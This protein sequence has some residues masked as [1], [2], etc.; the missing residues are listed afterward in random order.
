MSNRTE[1]DHHLPRAVTSVPV[2]KQV[3]PLPERF[4]RTARLGLPCWVVD[5]EI[6]IGR[7]V[8]PDRGIRLDD[9]SKVSK[10]H[11]FLRP[12]GDAAEIVDLGSKNH[13][14]VDGHQVTTATLADSSGIRIGNTLFVLRIEKAR[15]AD[16][17]DSERVIHERLLGQSQE[18][19][20]LRHAL[21]TAAQSVDPVLLIGPTGAGKELAATAIHTLSARSSRPFVPVN[22]AAIPKG[23]AESALFGHRRGAFT[24]ADRDHDGYFKQAD[25][26]TLF[27]D[28]IGELSLEVQAKLLR[29]LQPAEPGQP[30][31]A[32]RNILRIQS[33]GGQSEI[34][35]DVRVIAATNVDLRHAVAKGTFRED[36][37]HRLSVLPISLPG[38]TERREDILPIL[39]HYLN[40]NRGNSSLRRVSA[41][42]GELLLL[43]RWPGNVRE[44]ENLSKRLRSL[45]PSA[46]VIDLDGLP[47]DLFA[48]FASENYS[49]AANSPDGERDLP[50][51]KDQRI[52]FELLSRL[53]K[54]NESKISRVARILGRS[55]KQIRRRMDAFGIPRPHAKG[56]GPGAGVLHPHED[57]DVER[58]EP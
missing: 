25:A 50:D 4:M 47:D 49:I 33:Y 6:P 20:V 36:L 14:F 23:A 57:D 38:L 43:H 12:R 29:A 11:A 31:P 55:S 39:L 17:P 27:L 10:Q 13:T 35:V 16:A 1:T 19:R 54:E 32:G 2:L 28:E 34:N 7:E 42:L 48:E 45:V 56:S 58:E 52:T 3:L 37:F 51:P 40:Q 5:G 15:V 22:C 18:V 46:E 53:L 30:R 9:D 41:R 21:S 8:D 24:G 44:L 26:G